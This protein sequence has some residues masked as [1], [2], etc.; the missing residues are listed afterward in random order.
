MAEATSTTTPSEGVPPAPEVSTTQQPPAED[1][2]QKQ[3][4][5]EEEEA[6]QLE[7]APFTISIVLPSGQTTIEIPVRCV[8]S[9]AYW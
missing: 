4:A 9:D 1:T 8:A 7:D 2:E 6:E 3:T 5:E